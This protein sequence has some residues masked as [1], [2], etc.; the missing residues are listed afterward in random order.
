MADNTSTIY[1]ADNPINDPR[2]K[3]I[4]ISYHLTREHRIRK[5]FTLSYVPSN[6]D[7]AALM[8]KGLNS[9]AHHLHTQ[10]LGLSE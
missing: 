2:T 7:T 6:D 1:V 3:D 8:T 9:V 4:D 10:R 5:S